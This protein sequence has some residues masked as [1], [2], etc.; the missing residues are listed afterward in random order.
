MYV[1]LWNLGVY[2]GILYPEYKTTTKEGE[3]ISS[4]C[5]NDTE[6]GMEGKPYKGIIDKRAGYIKLI[7]E[8]LK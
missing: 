3:K 5:A 4:N 7:R 1:V 2:R 8:L 6:N